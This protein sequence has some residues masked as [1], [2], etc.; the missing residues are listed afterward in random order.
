MSD[1]DAIEDLWNVIRQEV[2]ED[3]EAMEFVD[4]KLKEIHATFKDG[5]ADT[6]VCAAFVIC[7]VEDVKNIQ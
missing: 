3:V 1:I 2:K 7:V 4:R 5:E 6:V